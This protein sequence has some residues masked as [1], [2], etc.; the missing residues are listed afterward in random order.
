MHSTPRCPPVIPWAFASPHYGNQRTRM[1]LTAGGLVGAAAPY[2]AIN[3]RLR[4]VSADY[5]EIVR[6]AFDRLRH[7]VLH[8]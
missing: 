8:M 2:A 3:M 5:A 7:R 6:A 4:G 1:E